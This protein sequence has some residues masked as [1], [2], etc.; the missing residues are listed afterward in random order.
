MKLRCLAWAAAAL[1]VSVGSASAA[2]VVSGTIKGPDCA[3]LRAVWIRAENADTKRTTSVLSNNQGRYRVPDLPP[4]K[5][6]IWATAVGWRST[7]ARLTDVSVAE[8][9]TVNQDFAMRSVPVLWHELTKAQAIA[10]MPEA[11]GRERFFTSC[12]NCHGMGKMVGRRDVDGWLDAI[13]QM[14]RVGV[15]TIN[16][17]I[18]NEVAGY[19]A[20]VLGPDSPTPQSPASL[21]AY[22]DLTMQW[23]DEALNIVYVDFPVKAGPQGRPGVGEMDKAGMIW[24]ETDNGIVRLNPDTGETKAFYVPPDQPRIGG[25][26][27]VTR[28]RFDDAIWWLTGTGSNTIAKFDSRADKWEVYK[29]PATA[30]RVQQLDPNTPDK[31]PR[32]TAEGEG[33][34][35]AGRKHTAMVD[36]DGNVWM[37]GRPLTKFNPKTKEWKAF[38]DVPD[39][40][41]IDMDKEGN[42]WVA[43]FN[44]AANGSVVKVDR[45]TNK[46]TKFKPPSAAGRPRRLHIDS[47]GNVMFGQYFNGSIGKLDP[48]TGDITEIK[49]PGAYPTVYGFGIDKNDNAWGVSH[50][51]EATFR[52]DPTGKVIA[53][54]SPYYTRGSRDL[55]VDAQNRMWECIQP[56]YRIGY[57][58]LAQP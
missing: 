52:V 9:Q 24:M 32:V 57:F 58:Y 56:D 4:G 15:T 25:V 50:F 21:P 13:D 8:G 26:H 48:K 29:D 42:I 17:K 37:T 19:L 22:K 46:V 39:V 2:G 51:N 38:L 55:K 28:D 31:F 20:A 11:P 18:A 23:G 12:M 53:Y 54:P 1:L 7:P 49:L 41:G 10:L 30:P 16:P 27:E 3:A 14:R 33:Q 34:N 36:L 35:G 6:A 47:K 5:Y 45:N 43:E 44:S 40:Y